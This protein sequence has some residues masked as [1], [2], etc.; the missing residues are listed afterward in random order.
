MNKGD[1]KVTSGDGKR[2]TV[3]GEGLD[4]YL[5][6]RGQWGGRS[7]GFPEKRGGLNWPLGGS[8]F[9]FSQLKYKASFSGKNYRVKE[10][11]DMG[12]GGKAFHMFLKSGA[13]Q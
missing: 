8:Y 12:S 4:D 9:L 1:K 2:N 11:G 3:W 13:T 10:G 7:D 6:K 5:G